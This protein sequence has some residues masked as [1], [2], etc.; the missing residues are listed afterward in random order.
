[1]IKRALYRVVVA[2]LFVSQFLFAQI[3]HGT[4]GHTIAPNKPLPSTRNVPGRVMVGLIQ[5]IDTTHWAAFKNWNEG[6]VVAAENDSIVWVGTSVGLLRWN[7]HDGSFRTYDESD[8]LPFTVV[9]GLSFDIWHRLWISTTQG[10]V[11]YD[12][13]S[14]SAFSYQNANL[15]NGQFSCIALDSLGRIYVGCEWWLEDF[16]VDEGIAIYDGTS[17]SY[18]I[19]SNS[20][21]GGSPNAICVYHDTLWIG[22]GE[23]LFAMKGS[24]I[25]PAPGWTFGGVY[26]LAVDYQDSLWAVSNAEN[27]YKYSNGTW[28]DIIDRDSEHVGDLWE[29]IWNDPSGGLWLLYPAEWNLQGYGPYR[30][31]IQARKNG[32]PGSLWLPN[33]IYK[34]PGLTVQCN[35][36]F[37]YSAAAQYFASRWG[38][39]KF[40]G[41]SW[42]S[43]IVPRTLLSNKIYSLGTSPAGVVYISEE[44]ATQKTDGVQWDSIGGLG[45]SNPPVRFHPDGSYWN[46]GIEGKYATGL[47]FDTYGTEW[48]AY[49]DVYSYN[50]AG[51][52]DW[53]SSDMGITW[54]SWSSGP[55]FMDL[56]VDRNDEVWACAWYYGG[57][58]YDRTHWHPVPTSDSTLPNSEYDRIFTDSHGRVWFS[59]WGLPNY[60][61][62]MFDGTHWNTY[63]S[64]HN[65]NISF[66]E[67]FAEDQFGNIWLATDGGLLKYDGVS[68]TLFDNT[69][70]LLNSNIVSSVTVDLANNVWIGTASG[71]YVFNPAGVCLGPYSFSNPTDSLG[72][73]RSGV[74]V[75]ATFKPMPLLGSSSIFELQR[76]RSTAR[77]WTVAATPLIQNSGEPIQLN[78][79][80]VVS[81]DY[82]YRIKRIDSDGRTAHSQ[83][84]NYSAG[85]DKNHL[86]DC[87]YYYSGILLY[88]KWKVQ[89]DPLVRGFELWRTDDSLKP[90]SLLCQ[91]PSS[92]N[93][94]DQ[95]YYYFPVDS[96]T[97]VPRVLHYTLYSTLIDSS[98]RK[99]TTITVA[100]ELPSGFHISNNY[101]NPFNGSTSFQIF[102]PVATRIKVRIYDIIGREVLPEI[103]Q[104]FSS[105]YQIIRLSLGSL[106]SGVYLYRIDANGIAVNGKLVLIK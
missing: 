97:T 6:N 21:S 19:I 87:Q 91:L 42:R 83:S 75:A 28:L 78:D 16:S 5:N 80:T 14:F 94:D 20:Y 17:W 30:L 47:D 71:L 62:T 64:P 68:F 98:R 11:E 96:L 92:S 63:Y 3:Q 48:A 35:A 41:A 73:I 65:Y 99:L 70:S 67:Q 37:A 24:V 59:S 50:S 2:L 106:A 66:V 38:L 43:Y 55:Q 9:Q 82:C 52:K 33:G 56:C 26:S 105:G 86:L 29:S 93:R 72:V 39:L 77:F 101:P 74:A 61:F 46:D 49:G 81:G 89:N 22:G 79:S 12:G 34:V 25:S 36:Q 45:W 27:I 60:G 57:T 13:G 58:M 23:C 32:M 85:I 1:M 54:P 15:P 8:G 44:M 90:I 103:T 95:G 4:F 7:V 10:I 40:D 102:L 76:G 53:Q 104:D 88:I 100:P 84:V 31:D 51:L 18:Q 69:N